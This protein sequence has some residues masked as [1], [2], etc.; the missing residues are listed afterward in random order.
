MQDL[1]SEP[2]F[3]A[4]DQRKQTGQPLPSCAQCKE[5]KAKRYTAVQQGD[6]RMAEA[7]ATAMG[8]HQRAVHS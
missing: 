8:R 3:R 2:V 1:T 4:Q 5:I 6:Q 7:M